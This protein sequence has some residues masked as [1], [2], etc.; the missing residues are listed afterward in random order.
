MSKE[1][2]LDAGSIIS[3]GGTSKRRDELKSI[4]L[5]PNCMIAYTNRF[6]DVTTKAQYRL[7]NFEKVQNWHVNG[8]SLP[9][10]DD[11]DEETEVKLSITAAGVKAV[12]SKPNASKLAFAI[13]CKLF[14]NIPDLIKQLSGGNHVNMDFVEKLITLRNTLFSMTKVTGATIT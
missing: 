9:G 4:G 10:E 6:A 2:L 13:C 11:N 3:A 12:Y 5:N 14:G 7:D 1:L 8:I